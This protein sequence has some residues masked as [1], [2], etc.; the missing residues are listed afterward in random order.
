MKIVRKVNDIRRKTSITVLN[1]YKSH[2][3]TKNISKSTVKIQTV[4]NLFYV[5]G[6]V[7][8]N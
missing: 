3:I 5:K 7:L 6:L 2:S 8:S 1:Q 4:G